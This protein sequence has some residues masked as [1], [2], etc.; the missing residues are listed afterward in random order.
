MQRETPQQQL[1]RTTIETK[2][3]NSDAFQP[4][5]E[6]FTS[7]I[8]GSDEQERFLGWLLRPSVLPEETQITL[9]LHLFFFSQISIPIF[10]IY[11][12]IFLCSFTLLFHFLLVSPLLYV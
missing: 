10:G 2:V 11:F 4:Y 12:T 5:Y 3:L 8:R 7:Y 6:L 1:L 9:L